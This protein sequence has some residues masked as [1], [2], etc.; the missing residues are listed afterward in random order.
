MLRRTSHVIIEVVVA[1]AIGLAVLAGVAVWRFTQGPVSL[2]FFKAEIEAALSAA[3]APLEVR[4]DNTILTWVAE[5]SALH[6]RGVGL[7]AFDANGDIVASAPEASIHLSLRALLRGL[8]APTTVEL[9]GPRIRLVRSADGIFG[10]G[11]GGREDG[12]DVRRP[13]SLN[14]LGDLGDAARN[15]GYLTRLVVTNGDLE[16]ADL[17]SG[18]RWTA[19]SA[20][21]ALYRDGGDISGELRA[22]LNIGPS[23]AAIEISARHRIDTGWVA[24]DARVANLDASALGDYHD[25]LK[26]LAA[27]NSRIDVRLASRLGR[28]GRFEST[29]FEL[30]GAKGSLAMTEHWPNGL[31]FASI[32]AQGRVESAPLRIA[33]D[34]FEADLGGPRLSIRAHAAEIAGLLAIDGEATIRDLPIPTLHSFWPPTAGVHPRR[35]VTENM[36]AGT[37]HET[38]FGFSLRLD[39]EG[40]REAQIDSVT[41]TMRLSG[42]TV[43]YLKPLPPIVNAQAT[44][45]FTL[46]GFDIAVTGG[47]ARGLRV[48]SGT[49]GISGFNDRDQLLALELVIAGPFRDAL[50]ILD[51]PRFDFMR[52]IGVDAAMTDG[53]LATRL[54]MKF[55]LVNQLTFDNIDIRAV[56]NLRRASVKGIAYGFDLTDG[57]LLLRVDK[58]GMDVTGEA[59]LADVPAKLTWYESFDDKGAQ[60]RRYDVAVTLDPAAQARL[61]LEFAPY[62]AGP[63]AIEM[64]Y[65]ETDRGQG[66]V[67]AKLGLGD[68]EFSLPLLGWNKAK[69]EPA[70]ATISALFKNGRL[71]ELSQF[72]LVS[73]RLRARGSLTLRADGKGIDRARLDRFSLDATDLA[74]I[75]ARTGDGFQLTISGASLDAAPFLRSDSGPLAKGKSEG[76]SGLPPLAITLDLERLWIGN[77]PPIAELRGSLAY[78]GASWGEIALDGTLADKHDLSLRFGRAGA[79]DT[80]VVRGADAGETLRAFGIMER[81]NGGKFEL[82]AKRP[83]RAGATPWKGNLAITDFSLRDAP[84]LARLL[85]LASLTGI[86]DVVSGQALRFSRLDVPFTF[87]DDVIAMEGA[88][89]VGSELGITASGTIDLATEALHLDGTVAPA[90]TLNS[91][92]GNIPIIGQI[93][94][95]EK[96]AGIFAATYRAVGSFDDPKFNVNPFAA[97]TPGILRNLFFGA[98]KDVTPGFGQEPPKQ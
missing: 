80:V 4:L 17:R 42:L 75:L 90:Y 8:I 29:S 47:Q 64:A 68:T 41:G 19:P 95:G 67:A 31:P 58:S 73:G 86:A 2:G 25:S 13:R 56:S 52:K 70:E 7:H 30:T 9:I 91:I 87:K 36:T 96:G 18:R 10:L 65:V 60:R 34:R 35:W 85:T 54:A 66:E 5:R 79:G 83:D 94:T 26:P 15:L 16:V 61:G 28:D 62:A 98:H 57:A 93:L 77:G 48:P 37:I 78:D 27:L 39:P 74:L 23:T 46:D 59:R 82:T 49:I 24:L 50:E 53:V 45:A 92:L 51:H 89:A 3:V 81:V 14:R 21:I 76:E 6:I 71:A 55:M 72:D 43:H 69:G 12:P 44:A 11:V 22:E 84:A 32:V 88:R 38:R 33:L 20:N 1:L 97:L 63:V 40:R